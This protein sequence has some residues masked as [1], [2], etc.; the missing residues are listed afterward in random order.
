MEFPDVFAYSDYRTFLQDWFKVHKRRTGRKGTSDFA[1]MAGCSPGHVRNVVVGRRDLQAIFIEGFVRALGLT[2]ED[3]TCFGLLVR[4]IHPLS[5]ADR[6][7]AARELR[8]LQ[9]AHGAPV[10]APRRGR[11]RKVR[12]APAGPERSPSHPYS[13]WF[14]PVIRALAS[15][16]GFQDNPTWIASSLRPAISPLQVSSLSRGERD[17]LQDRPGLPLT[18]PYGDREGR[19]YHRSALRAARWA[20]HNVER[21]ERQFGATTTSLCPSQLARLRDEIARFQAEIEELFARASQGSYIEHIRSE[22]PAPDSPAVVELRHGPPDVIYQLTIQ[23]FP[24][25]KRI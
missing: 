21:S 11:P 20:L 25:S 10:A 3:A 5:S 7:Q 13:E 9:Q 15:C 1:R 22:D 6:M 24:L 17:L 14:H 23:V 2:A 12:A 16:P 8:A 4:C 18:V 19:P